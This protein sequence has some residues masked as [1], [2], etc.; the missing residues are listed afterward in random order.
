MRAYCIA[1]GTLLKALTQLCSTLCDPVDCSLPGFSV[2]GILQERIL[3]WVTISFSN[4]KL[5]GDL[6]RKETQ[7]GGNI[8][9]ADS[10][11]YIVETNAAL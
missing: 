10:F 5:Y 3:E 9:M 4:L 1:Q 2:H 11:C 7:K 8:C 6:N